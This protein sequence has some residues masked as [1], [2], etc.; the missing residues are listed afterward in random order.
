MAKEPQIDS[1]KLT[2]EQLLTQAITFGLEV[3]HPYRIPIGDILLHRFG[4]DDRRKEIIRQQIVDYGIARYADAD[5][6]DLLLNSIQ[7]KAIE[8]GN[9]IEYMEE[10][11]EEQ[12]PKPSIYADN[13]IV[14]DN[15][16]GNHLSQGR[17]FL[18]SLSPTIN[19]VPQQAQPKQKPDTTNHTFWDKAKYISVIIGG[20]AGLAAMIT[21]IGKYFKWW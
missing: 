6:A 20:L 8:S 21:G 1:S 5:E 15:N 19:T 13:S 12:K 9:P 17:D 7:V 2:D 11:R 3:H 18:N 10:W 14:G 16:A 4:C